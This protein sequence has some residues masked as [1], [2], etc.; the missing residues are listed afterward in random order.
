MSP[1]GTGRLRRAHDAHSRAA[2]RTRGTGR[3]DSRARSGRLALTEVPT[4][5]HL[6]ETS[7]AREPWRGRQPSKGACPLPQPP[8]H[9]LASPPRHSSARRTTASPA[10]RRLS[11]LLDRQAGVVGRG[12]ALAAGLTPREDRPAARPAALGSG[13]PARLPR[14]RPA[15]HRRGSGPG[16]GA[17]GG[18][19]AVVVGAAAVWWHGLWSDGPGSRARHGRGRRPAPLPA[20]RP[21]VS[22][23]RQHLPAA[24]V[25]TV[26]GSPSPSARSPCSTPPSRPEPGGPALLRRALGGDVG[27][28]ERQLR[29]VA[30][31][32]AGTATA[33]RLIAAVPRPGPRRPRPHRRRRP[34]RRPCGNGRDLGIATV[35][36]EHRT[37]PRGRHGRP[38][39]FPR[40]R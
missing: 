22:A 39:P 25:V 4:A 2:P 32:S 19:G 34:H 29:A 35:S 15:S 1:L 28:T 13:A 5:E 20:A 12:Q 24:E 17:V 6:A 8:S 7:R 11:A 26:R 18:D 38:L 36:C 21:G 10:R 30:A 31:S 3:A 40:A 23:R 37:H 14:R 27:L 16:R 33:A 9:R